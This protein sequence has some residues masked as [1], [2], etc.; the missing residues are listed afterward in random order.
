MLIDIVLDRIHI[1]IHRPTAEINQS[2][3]TIPF[4]VTKHDI[5]YAVIEM[6]KVEIVSATKNDNILEQKS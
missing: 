5:L 4:A 2:K 1:I 6:V 3:I